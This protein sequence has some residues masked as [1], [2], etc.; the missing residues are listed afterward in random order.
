MKNDF[1]QLEENEIA[2]EKQFGVAPEMPHP[3]PLSEF[4]K[5]LAAALESGEPLDLSWDPE[6]KI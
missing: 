2:Y 3:M 4:N 1:E 5:L 6:A